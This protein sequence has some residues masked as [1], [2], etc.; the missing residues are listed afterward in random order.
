MK[1][2]IT[3][4]LIIGLLS[5]L[6]AIQA[7]AQRQ[8]PSAED[9]TKALTD[10]LSLSKEQSAKVLMIFKDADAKRQEV[11]DSNSGDRDAQRQAMRGVMEKTDQRIDSLL[12]ATQKTKYDA[13]KTARMQRWQNRQQPPPPAPPKDQSK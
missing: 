5:C 10:S 11:F 13:M 2:R 4:F 8:M 7:S 6:T 3:L 9:R 12:T 1:H